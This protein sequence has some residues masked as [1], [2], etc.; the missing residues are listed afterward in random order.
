MGDFAAVVRRFMKAR[1]MSVRDTARAA[2]YSDHTLLS[3]VLNGHKPAT[4]YLAACLDDALG[5]EGAI[6]TA[7]QE[8]AGRAG[9]ARLPLRELADH[10]AEFGQFAETGSAGPGTIATLEDEV[11]RLARE[12]VASPPGPLILRASDACRR[13]SGLL[14]QHQRLRHARDL[15]VIGA[16]CCA[17]LGVAL[18]DLGQR[19]EAAAYARTALILAE[20]SGD[21]GA[22]AVALSAESKVAFWDGRPQHAAGLAARGYG[23][24]RPGDPVRVLLACQQADASSVPRAREALALASAA[25]GE[26]DG[27][28]PGLFTCEAVRLAAYTSTL[29]LREGDPAGVL[30]AAAAAE[31][32]VRDGEAAQ[33]GSWMQVRISAALALLDTGDAEQAAEYLGPVLELAPEMRLATFAAKLSSAA[34]VA[35]APAYRGSSAARGIVEGIS[36]YLGEDPGDLMPYPLA[37]APGA[38]K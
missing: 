17:F 8:A 35:S 20:E 4:P 15:Y 14:R 37:L 6:I 26:T 25:R 1:G 32:A 2:G 29:R 23:L 9:A 13:V 18:G 10:A 33:A 34:R 31:A 7:A 38:G 16:R 12:Y 11:A 19:A 36:A 21:P 22:V 28:D 5:A 3:K 24:A 27:H 30:A